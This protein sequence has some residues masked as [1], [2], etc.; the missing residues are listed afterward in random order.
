MKKYL[1]AAALIVAA[2]SVA[3]VSCKKDNAPELE[4]YVK[5]N[6][7][8]P[9]VPSAKEI[10]ERG[11]VDLGEMN[12]LLLEKVEELARYVIELQKQIDEMKNQNKERE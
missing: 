7:H 3:M 6:S 12:V 10:G 5:D 1:L 11:D 2:V 4:A 8:L 9:G